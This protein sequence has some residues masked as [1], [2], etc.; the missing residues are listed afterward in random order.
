[1]K[2]ISLTTW[3]DLKDGHLYHEGDKFPFDDREVSPERIAELETGV[4]RAGLKLIR[5][6]EVAV[7]EGQNAENVPG[8]AENDQ[9]QASK[10]KAEEKPAVKAEKPKTAAKT[11]G[12]KPKAK[13]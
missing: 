8:G 13:K 11:A 12:T 5:A 3:R 6:D 1:M 10:P 9:E 7:P 2:Y 4:N